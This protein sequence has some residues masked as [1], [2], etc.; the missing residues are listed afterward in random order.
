MAA[1]CNLNKTISI[2]GGGGGQEEE[3]QVNR[4]KAEYVWY[5]MTS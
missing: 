2:S 3:G 4:D 5:S 1:M